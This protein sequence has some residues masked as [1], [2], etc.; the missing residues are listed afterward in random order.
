M[1]IL[2]LNPKCVWKNFYALTQIP[3]PSKHE[4]KAVEFLV[5][6]GKKLGLET[7]KDEIGNVII[8][9][10]AT[11]GMENRKGIILQAHVDMVP[12]KT[13]EKKHDFEK[14]PITTKIVDFEDGKWVCADG[15]TLGA[16]NGL[17]CAAIMAVLEAKDIA[18]GPIEGLFT[19]DEETGMTGAHALKA[20][21]INGEILINLDS[22]TEGELYVGCA[23]GLDCNAEFKYR[24]ED[25]PKGYKPFV[26]N[27]KG[28][29]GGHSG[30]DIIEGRCN[31]N[32][33]LARV[34]LPLTRDMDC[35]LVSI[36]GG[37]LRNAIPLE[38]TATVAVPADSI[39]DVKALVA[40][41]DA[42]VRKEYFRID[43]NTSITIEAS[44]ARK[45]KV[46][47][48]KV[49]LKLAEA[50][51]CCPDGVDRMSLEMAGLV[52]SSN[53]MAI[54][55]SENG[56]I[57]INGLMRAS[58]DSIKYAQAERF[59]CAFE[60]AGA[61]VFFKGGY[62][63]WQPNIDSPILG[64]MKAKYKELFGVEPGV[65]AIHAGLECGILGGIYP[66]W[67]MI[68]C[69][70]TLKSPHSPAERANIASVEKWWKFVVAVLEDAPAK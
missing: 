32:K 26:I 54:V 67:D 56:K 63:G 1:T 29:R 48:G 47:A 69:G 68:S 41:I 66:N 3:R 7:I 53:N 40:D 28:L 18:H 4:Q 14:D 64:T 59:R 42:T 31:A 52:E 2:D 16:D 10:P 57:R 6:F 45:V 37:S 24:E 17:G 20:G 58:T 43:P 23:G 21:V 51:I 11:K 34:L 65:M 22:E 38:A 50:L 12:Q 70:P 35:K 39:D 33:L 61:K 36:E 13:N 44:K 55:K 62:S 9:K 8:R 25:M 49:G 60:L 5:D 19:I 46:M 27:V 15:T 30:M